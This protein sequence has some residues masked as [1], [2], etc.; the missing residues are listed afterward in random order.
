MVPPPGQLQGVVWDGHP[1][2]MF[3]VPGSGQG[4]ELGNCFTEGCS[5]VI[6]HVGSGHPWKQQTVAAIRGKWQRVK[7]PH[8]KKE[9]RRRRLE[10]LHRPGTS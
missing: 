10:D 5:G 2:L 3:W 4:Q 6:G 7:L 8:E 9:N 1:T